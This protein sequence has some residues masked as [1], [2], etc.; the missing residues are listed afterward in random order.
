V[1]KTFKQPTYNLSLNWKFNSEGLVYVAHRLGYRAGGFNARA[2]SALDFAPFE[3]ETARDVEL[4]LK[5]QMN[6]NGVAVRTNLAGYYQWYSNIQRS[7]T[8]LQ[9]INGNP[10]TSTTV[11]NA[12]KATIKGIEAEVTVIPTAGLEISGTYA[13]TRPKYSRFVNPSNGA[14]LSNNKFANVPENSGTA[15]VSYKL[16]LESSIGEVTVSADVYFQSSIQSADVNENPFSHYPGYHVFSARVGWERIFGSKVDAAAF[17]R[18][19]SNAQ[20]LVSGGSSLGSAG[21]SLG[22]PGEPRIYGIQLRYA[23]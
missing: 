9:N 12:A 14:D 5:Y 16:P 3:A 21:Y 2:Q 18:N 6:L 7:V 19:I 11:F 10:V 1:S 20:Y 15:Q 8:I 4:G 23:Y 22:Y 13:Y 17:V